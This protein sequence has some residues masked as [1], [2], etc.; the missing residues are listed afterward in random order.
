MND[1][2]EFDPR[3][4]KDYYR[5]ERVA[6]TS[7]VLLRGVTMRRKYTEVSLQML[8]EN[9]S[10]SFFDGCKTIDEAAK[11]VNIVKEKFR[12]D[13]KHRYEIFIKR[14]RDHNSKR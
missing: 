14:M 6:D 1:D 2:A 11:F 13:T 8:A 5:K 12:D 10:S 7:Q 3:R 9:R 4:E